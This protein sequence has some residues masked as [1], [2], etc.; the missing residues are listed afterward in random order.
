MANG[1]EANGLKDDELLNQAGIGTL[2]RGSDS[3]LQ[4]RQVKLPDG[5]VGQ[6][7]V[8]MSGTDYK[9]ENIVK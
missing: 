2:E 4:V 5:R 1:N 7:I 6:V 9:P 8:R 3:R